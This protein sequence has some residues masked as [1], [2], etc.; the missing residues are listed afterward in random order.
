MNFKAFLIKWI[1]V[2]AVLWIVLGWFFG[3]SF[4]D[5]LITS[6]VLTVIGYVG[7]AFILPRVGNVFAAITDFVLAYAVVWMMGN[8]LIEEPIALGTASFI[9]ALIITVG[10][11]FFHRFM[12]NHVIDK[13][14]TDPHDKKGYYQQ[15]N[16]QTEFGEDIDIKSDVNDAKVVN[17][18]DAYTAT[19]PNRP[20][21]PTTE[22]ASEFDI[23]NVKKPKN[24][25]Q[26]ST[27]KRGKKKKK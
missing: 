25:N 16:L 14:T 22:F 2:L 7:D 8:M 27:K 5:I 1:M 26:P 9:S 24:K 12:G 13:E 6:V 11:L 18:E 20:A 17:K 3:V 4:T 23:E 10:E 15:G 21:K 19:T